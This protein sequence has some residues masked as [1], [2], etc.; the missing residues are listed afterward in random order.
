MA[1]YTNQAAI[2]AIL[3]RSLTAS[4]ITYLNALLPAIDAYIN[5]QTGTTFLPPSPDVDVDVYEQGPD[6][7]NYNNHRSW[8]NRY[9]NYNERS[10]GNT[11]VI[12]TMRS[13]TSVATSTGFPDNFVTVPSTE[14]VIYPRSGPIL[15]LK[16]SGSWG[17][18]ET[19]IKITG[20]LGYSTVPSIIGA[21]AAA[22]GAS[23]ITASSNSAA[24]SGGAYKS[25]KVGDWQVTY[26]DGDSSSSSSS[27]VPTI[28]A[29]AF[30]TLQGY[31]RLS[32]DI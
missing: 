15:A 22:M 18:P 19:T 16:R 32:R 31:R 2:E 26:S 21:I 8:P 10:G 17:S 20:K 30:E 25:E 27:G 14:W 29:S 6:D 13:V 28:S 9:Y 5:E 7:T 1:N 3:Q 4:E 11:L 23:A 12:P 24:S